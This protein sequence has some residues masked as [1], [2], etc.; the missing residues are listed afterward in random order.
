MSHQVMGFPADVVR[1]TVHHILS[2]PDFGATERI[3]NFLKYII[4]ET[5]EG[6]AERI[7]AYTIATSVFGRD[8]NFDPQVDSIVRIE[9]GRLRRT[10][11]RYYLTGGRDD[12]IQIRIPV[13]S[14]VPVIIGRETSG[15]EP[16]PANADAS[17]A[18]FHRGPAIL[19]EPFEQEGASATHPH[20]AAGLTQSLV[21]RLTRFTGLRVYFTS[22]QPETP[23][24]DQRATAPVPDYVLRGVVSLSA[25][26]LSVDI[27]L[28]KARS[29]RTVWADS[30]DSALLP[31]DF[32][33]LRDEIANRVAQIIAQPYGIIFTDTAKDS[34]GDPPSMLSSYSCVLSFY[35]YWK[36]FDR[37]M[38]APTRDCLERTIRVDPNYAEAFACLSLLYSNAHRFGHSLGPLTFDLRERALELANRAIELAPNSAWSHYARSVAH[39]FANDVATSIRALETG[40]Q[41][42]PNDT[43]IL[44]ELGQRY[45]FLMQWD[46]AVPLLETAFDRNPA[47][48]TGYRIGMFLYHLAHG[49]YQ[50]ALHEGRRVLAPSVLY[51]HVAIAI[52]AAELGRKQEAV[53]AVRRILEID[54]AYGDRVVRDL[55][56]RN[57][58]GDLITLVI[59]GLR[60]A[61]L[62]GSEV[63]ALPGAHVSA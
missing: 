49:R 56:S 12:E 16:V 50:E 14:Y 20:F 58:H 32:F 57:L 46:K 53:E 47:Q 30:F 24:G 43:T 59:Q 36:T 45:A 1:D 6:R 41:L 44:A 62:R 10:L 37:E 8:K 51:G 17:Q 34:D 3:R 23:S 52:A 2:S 21:V 13:G 5:L 63:E 40:R 39:W 18:R 9:A 55:E 11:E 19:V 29:G 4:E 42:N 25:D 60:K 27:V 7:K 31:V 33:S 38:I 54:P 22:S 35:K 15:V 48:P 61:G 26:H 28:L